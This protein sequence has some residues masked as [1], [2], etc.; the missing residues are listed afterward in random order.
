ME[1]NHETGGLRTT[2][3]GWPAR[4]AAKVQAGARLEGGSKEGKGAGPGGGC[5]I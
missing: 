2:V 1:P 4:Q 5:V 3:L